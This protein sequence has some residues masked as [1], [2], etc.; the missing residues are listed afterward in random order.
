[1]PREELQD[2]SKLLKIINENLKE[3]SSF[4]E[5][6]DDDL[7]FTATKQ[8][9]QPT[10]KLKSQFTK[11]TDSLLA[12]MA[13]KLR[14][15]IGLFGEI[16]GILKE[17]DTP[18]RVKALLHNIVKSPPTSLRDEKWN[19]VHHAI[20]L[21]RLETL[22]YLLEDQGCN[23]VMAL[24]QTPP[25]EEYEYVVPSRRQYDILPREEHKMTHEESKSMMLE[26]EREWP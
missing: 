10:V 2:N 3:A 22:R 4:S 17:G 19:L 25:S 18:L 9:P 12:H 11:E 13:S 24:R 16:L 8:V 6:E 26:E 7:D 23:V 20:H 15:S 14:A 1:L 21:R 5:S